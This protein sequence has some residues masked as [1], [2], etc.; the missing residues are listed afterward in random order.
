MIVSNFIGGCKTIE[1]GSEVKDIS[2]VKVMTQRPDGKFDVFCFDGNQ[3]VRSREELL[4]NKVCEAN[5]TPTVAHRCEC[6]SNNGPDLFQIGFNPDTNAQIFETKIKGWNNVSGAF[7]ECWDRIRT[8][9]LCRPKGLPEQVIARC[10]CESN[11]GPDLQYIA[12]D[13]KAGKQLWKTKINGW[14]NVTG[15][16]KECWNSIQN[17]PLCQSGRLPLDV[18]RKCECKSNNGPDLIQTGIDASTGKEIWST[19]IDGWDNSSESFQECFT[20]TRTLKACQLGKA[21][22]DTVGA[23]CF[24]KSNNGPD[25]VRALFDQDTGETLSETKI[26]G[27]SN[28]TGNFQKCWESISSESSCTSRISEKISRHCKCENN[29]GPDLMQIAIRL[30]D[31]KEVW[32]TKLMGWDKV[33]GA[34]DKCFEMLKNSPQCK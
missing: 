21:T 34:T 33:T 12:E 6:R 17:E 32:K 8:D 30:S 13:F 16:S 31:S 10:E 5:T 1:E 18:Y 25:L 26:N 9:S 24:C 14:S 20:A 11:N 29:N 19:K 27:W 15:A 2:D 3:E 22:R 23:R 7:S 28:Q 4:A